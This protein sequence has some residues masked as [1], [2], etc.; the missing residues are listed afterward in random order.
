MMDKALSLNKDSESEVDQVRFV[1]YV[2][3]P[4]LQFLP[5]KFRYTFVC[6]HQ[7][8]GNFLWE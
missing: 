2:I 8:L 3:T 4:G 7:A 1:Y 6:I 5:S